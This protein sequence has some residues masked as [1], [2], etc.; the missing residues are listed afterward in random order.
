[1]VVDIGIGIVVVQFISYRLLGGSDTV[2]E[3]PL[4]ASVLV[5]EVTSFNEVGVEKRFEVGAV[6]SEN[7][8]TCPK[9][10]LLLSS[11]EYELD[12][13]RFGF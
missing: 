8:C 3:F 2:F 1:M 12:V 5:A 7:I 11:F 6:F 10:R 4:L 13:V 9:A